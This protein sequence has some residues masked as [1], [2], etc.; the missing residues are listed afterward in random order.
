VGRQCNGGAIFVNSGATLTSPAMSPFGKQG[1]W[2]AKA[3]PAAQLAQ[4]PGHR[5]FMRGLDRIESARAPATCRDVQRR[6]ADDVASSIGINPKAR[7]AP[8]PA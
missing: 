6:I 4:A 5:L 3:R 1:R 2:G 8:V 7:P